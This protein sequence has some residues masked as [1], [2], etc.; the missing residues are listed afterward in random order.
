MNESPSTPAVQW[1]AVRLT[2][3]EPGDVDGLVGR[4][5]HVT[6]G[7]RR[8]FR[9][10]RALL[11]LLAGGDAGLDAATDG[12][13]VAGHE[14]HPAPVADP[15]VHAVAVDSR[16]ADALFRNP[17]RTTAPRRLR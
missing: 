6:T 1:Y 13:A 7:R 9:G 3:G 2:V 5:E 4:L 10:G 16:A 14:A 11:D 17:G 12:A 8:D 15:A